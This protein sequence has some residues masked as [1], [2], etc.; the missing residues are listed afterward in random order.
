MADIDSPA[1]CKTVWISTPPRTGST[2]LFN[3]TREILRRAGR[4]VLPERVPNDDKAMYELAQRDA[5]A[6][7]DPH[8]I[9][10]LKIHG[11][12]LRSDLPRSKIIT[13]IRDPRDVLVSFRQFMDTSFEHALTISQGVKRYVEGYR[14]HPTDL[15]LRVEYEDIESRPIDVLRR[16][17]GFLDVPLIAA[18]A[19][20]I[21]AMFGRE[22]VRQQ[23][24]ELSQD[25]RQRLSSG[26]AVGTDEVI[27]RDQAIVRAFDVGTG[28]Q[29]G[30][31]SDHKSG[32]W[33]SLLSDEEKR[34]VH[35][36]F[37][38]WFER[39]GYPPG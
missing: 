1:D 12:I 31:V 24:A 10:V 6:D 35:E 7:S 3:V 8:R 37:G 15:L 29:T 36:R 27:L 39:H 19:A 16:V 33:R 11:T 26:A 25:L 5:W 4:E 18:D 14:D 30:H 34:I 2:W 28:F 38:D 21:V 23:V 20:E 32:D 13:C 22:R 9:W 17:A